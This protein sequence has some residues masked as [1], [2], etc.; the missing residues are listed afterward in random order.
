MYE[1][2]KALIGKGFV[3]KKEQRI[4]QCKMKRGDLVQVIDYGSG[5]ASHFVI[6]RN[7]RL[8]QYQ[9][10]CGTWVFESMIDKEV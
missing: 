7:S 4:G 1:R 10:T 6:F 5:V 3:V 8:P 9:F 2:E